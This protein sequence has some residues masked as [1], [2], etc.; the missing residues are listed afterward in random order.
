MPTG[1]TTPR[2]KANRYQEPKDSDERDRRVTD[3][4]PAA[5]RE[6]GSPE[7]DRA[8]ER[9][10]EGLD[11]Q[12]VGDERRRQHQDRAPVAA[13]GELDVLAALRLATAAA[14]D[15]QG[16]EGG[17][18][19]QQAADDDRDGGGADRATGDPALRQQQRLDDDE[20]AQSPQEQGHSVLGAAL[21]PG[22]AGGGRTHARPSSLMTASTRSLSS[23]EERR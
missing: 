9:P 11:Q 20:E 16:E 4:V 10:A 2:P 21:L 3:V 12:G 23:V 5:E 1:R 17:D 19:H 18:D 8:G 13:P 22:A 14:G 15:V 7:E 6:G